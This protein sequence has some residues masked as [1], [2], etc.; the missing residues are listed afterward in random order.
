MSLI[1]SSVD[2]QLGPDKDRYLLQLPF[3]NFL[4]VSL[5]NADLKTVFSLGSGVNIWS[6]NNAKS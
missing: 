4:G 1:F 2:V 3:V 6:A 5:F